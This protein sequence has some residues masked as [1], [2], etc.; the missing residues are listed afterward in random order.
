M[1]KH[2]FG[3][4]KTFCFHD[5]YRDYEPEKFDCISIDDEYIEPL[6]EKLTELDT[7][8]F[9]G[10]RPQKGLNY[11]GIT[12]IPPESLA[13]FQK[14]L[15]QEGQPMFWPLSEKIDEAIGQ[16]RFMIHFGI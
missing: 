14:I 9:T 2:E 10:K 13:V 7:F 16:N 4:I 3:I 15:R 12:L 6:I 8:Y 1:A 11:Y 5:E